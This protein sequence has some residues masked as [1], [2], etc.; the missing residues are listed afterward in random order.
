MVK[1]F[2]EF[3]RR[4]IVLNWDDSKPACYGGVTVLNNF[5]DTFPTLKREWY[6][7]IEP[8]YKKEHNY[9]NSDV[10]RGVTEN[11]ILELEKMIQAVPKQ[12][13][14][15]TGARGM[16]LLTEAHPIRR[17]TTTDW[18]MFAQEQLLEAYQLALRPHGF[19]LMKRKSGKTHKKSPDK[20]HFFKPVSAKEAVSS[21]DYNLEFARMNGA[22]N[23]IC[24]EF[25]ASN[26]IRIYLHKDQKGKFVCTEDKKPID[27]NRELFR[28]V[29]VEVRGTGIYVLDPRLMHQKLRDV[30]GNHEGNYQR[31]VP[32][33][34]DLE[35]FLRRNPLAYPY[36]KDQFLTEDE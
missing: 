5:G 33:L 16:A 9:A 4:S 12:S 8:D 30:V 19:I 17:S 14:L 28:G 36:P 11:W 26:H 35:W 32:D 6:T 21:L 24:S 27:Y 7:V 10:S 2:D 31:H 25:I 20:Y 15:Y 29:P 3:I 23:A 18:A 13:R 1:W 22:E 34:K